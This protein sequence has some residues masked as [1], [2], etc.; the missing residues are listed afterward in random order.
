[1]LVSANDPSRRCMKQQQIGLPHHILQNFPSLDVIL[2]SVKMGIFSLGN[3]V[4]SLEA[5]TIKLAL[6]HRS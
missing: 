6:G 1:M 5:T 2:A 4:Y 3:Q